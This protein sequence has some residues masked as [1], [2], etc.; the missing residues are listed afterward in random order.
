MTLL[1][2]S[3]GLVGEILG[4]SWA[5]VDG[6]KT[7]KARIL[8][9]CKNLLLFNDSGLLGWPP[10]PRR[11]KGPQIRLLDGPQGTILKH[12]GSE[13]SH[14]KASGALGTATRQNLEAPESARESRQSRVQDPY[15]F[16]IDD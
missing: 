14:V 3:G 7:E 9:S 5:V 2:A 8:Q 11:P 12:V 15:V 4:T 10:G 6:L 16:S 13:G 1:G